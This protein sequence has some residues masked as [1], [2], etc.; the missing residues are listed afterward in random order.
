MD[1]KLTVEEAAAFLG[2][3]VSTLNRWRHVGTGPRYYKPSW[4]VW[5]DKK[6]LENWLKSSVV[7]PETDQ[8]SDTARN[9]PP[10]TAHSFSTSNE[11]GCDEGE[12][13]DARGGAS[14]SC[15]MAA[16]A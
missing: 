7:E 15:A 6:D 12:N 5:Y 3:S 4:Q 8:L 10:D 13:E 14:Q 16:E 1:D 9:V 11:G 2:F